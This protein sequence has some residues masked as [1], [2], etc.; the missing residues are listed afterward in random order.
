MKQFLSVVA[1]VISGVLSV[2]VIDTINSQLFPHES[3]PSDTT[4]QIEFIKSLPL[5]QLVLVV[6]AWIIGGFFGGLVTR[7]IDKING[8]RY[9][10]V[11]GLIITGLTLL[12]LILIPHPTWMW[13]VGLGGILPC[14]WLGAKVAGNLN[15]EF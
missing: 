3:L 13:I 9:A 10:L 7:L 12:N 14:A 11:T 15:P 1:G 4:A 2:A 6:M 8:A 5:M